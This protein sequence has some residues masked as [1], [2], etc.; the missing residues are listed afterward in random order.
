VAE[1]VSV[2]LSTTAEAL[3]LER[4]LRL[5]PASASSRGVF[6]NMLRE[7]MRKRGFLHVRELREILEEQRHSYG[8]YSTRQLVEAFA[9][10]GALVD[11]NPLEGMRDLFRTSPIQFSQSWYGRAMARYLRPDPAETLSWIERSRAHVANYGRWRV[12]HRGVRHAVLHMFDEYFWIDGALRGGCEGMLAACGVAGEVR[13]E[14]DSPFQGRF[15]VT[16]QLPS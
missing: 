6:F 16:W 5:I 13:V 12:E 10:A 3:D 4:R 8:L 15:H 9:I 2:N 14:L 7:D 1:A 11:E